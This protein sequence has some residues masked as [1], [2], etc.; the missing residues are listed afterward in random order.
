MEKARG[1]GDE[2]PYAA[3]ILMKILYAAR[4]ARF[5]FLRAVCGLAQFITRWDDECDR[6]LYV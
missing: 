2:N 1:G 6:K 4:M 5:D 3:K